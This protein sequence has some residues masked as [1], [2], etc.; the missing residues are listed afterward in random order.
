MVNYSKQYAILNQNEKRAMFKAMILVDIYL[1]I[2]VSKFSLS[3]FSHQTKQD[4][5]LV[6]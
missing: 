5:L 1:L 2:T 3:I 4:D 6:R